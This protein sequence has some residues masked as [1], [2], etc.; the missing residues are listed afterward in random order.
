MGKNFITFKCFVFF[1]GLLIVLG[2][3]GILA[4]VITLKMNENGILAR[5]A[6][7]KSNLKFLRKAVM[8]Y[9][10]EHGF[11]PCTIN[12]VNCQGDPTYFKRQLT[13][14]TNDKGEISQSRS[15]EFHYGP[16][17]QYFPENPFFEGTDPMIGKTIYVD[18]KNQRILEALKQAA[19]KGNGNSGWWYEAKSG[20]IVANLGCDVFSDN[21]CSF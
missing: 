9:H 13:W 1:L 8:T 15:D 12:D 4:T 19:K 2:V 11:F 17:L 6:V 14:F 3:I 7:L 16:Y 20:N 10:A 5:E 18:T 21:Y